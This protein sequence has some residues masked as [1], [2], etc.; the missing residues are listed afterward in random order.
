MSDVTN[1]DRW[2]KFYVPL[3]NKQIHMKESVI[4]LPHLSTCLAIVHFE[5]AKRPKNNLIV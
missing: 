4:L 1:S 5:M 2:N 3:K